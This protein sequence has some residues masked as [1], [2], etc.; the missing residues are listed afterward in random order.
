[1]RARFIAKT[2]LLGAALGILA[3]FLRQLPEPW[4]SLGAAAAPWV[5]VAFAMGIWA[6]SGDGPNHE[7]ILW[8]TGAIEAYLFAWLVSYH[9]TFAV[10]ESATIA[11]AWRQAWPYLLASVPASLALGGIGTF[12]HKGGILGDLCLAV[13]IAWT[14]PEAVGDMRYGGWSVASVVVPVAVLLILSA[15]AMTKERYVNGPA[16]CGYALGMAALG[17][18]LYPL[19]WWWLLG[20]Y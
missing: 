2:F 5:M 3:Q 17:M 9:A 7:K 13:P 6:S 12:S 14:V 1:M 10:R 16:L 19:A 4:M 18:V 8:A 20:R 11:G 15:Y